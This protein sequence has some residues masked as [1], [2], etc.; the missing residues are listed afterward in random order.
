MVHRLHRASPS[1]GLGLSRLSQLAT[2]NGGST[3]DARRGTWMGDEVSDEKNYNRQDQYVL[4]ICN[5]V[6]L[7]DT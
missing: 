5:F 4:N 6:V 1:F 2:A 3:L 7:M